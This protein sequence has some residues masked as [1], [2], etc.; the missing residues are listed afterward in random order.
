MD[1]IVAKKC[2]EETIRELHA[3][4]LEAKVIYSK[5]G[6]L[7]PSRFKQPRNVINWGCTTQVTPSDS[8]FN[9]TDSIAIASNKP[10]ARKLFEQNGVPTLKTVDFN[11]MINRTIIGRPDKHYGGKHFF[12]CKN[13]LDVEN[14]K[15]HGCTDFTYLFSKQREYRFH[16]M[17]NKVLLAQEKLGGDK[18]Q[19]VWN[20]STGFNFKLINWNSINLNMAKS[21]VD[22]VSSL[23]LDFGA[24]DIMSNQFGFVICEV[25]TAPK[26]SGYTAHKYA[27]AFNI[28]IEEDMW[29]DSDLYE[30]SSIIWDGMHPISFNV[31]YM[32]V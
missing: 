1:A 26:V 6:V 18:N 22:A 31:I 28:A 8:E 5:R 9:P 25:N 27:S 16:V 15:I 21:A 14:A 19:M 23:G 12:V 10:K 29:E 11:N 17:G 2:S 20:K 32:N 7:T 4:G 13:M 30:D 3:E 24:V